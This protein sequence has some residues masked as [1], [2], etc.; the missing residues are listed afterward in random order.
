L[1]NPGLL[2]EA[3]ER[4]GRVQELGRAIR[5][6]VSSCIPSAPA[7]SSI[8]VNLHAVELADD[9]LFSKGSP[10]SAHAGRVVLEVTERVSLHRITNLRG[11]VENLRTLGYRIAVDDLGAGYAGLSSFSQLEPDIAKLDMSLIRGIDTSASKESIVRAMITVCRNDLGTSVVCEGVETEAERDTLE[12][13]GAE[14]L[15]GYLF[16]RPERQFRKL[17]IFAPPN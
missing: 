16:A 12:G 9:D 13:L 1:S 4:L 10:L 2:F 7:D 17:S 14:L 15:Q 8:F 11:R 3:A 5:T 6:A